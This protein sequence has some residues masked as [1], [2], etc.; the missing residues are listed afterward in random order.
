MLF[1]C[2]GGTFLRLLLSFPP[3]PQC[4][5]TFSAFYS[6]FRSVVAT[7]APTGADRLPSH[8]VTVQLAAK[9]SSRVL[10]VYYGVRVRPSPLMLQH[11]HAALTCLPY[12]CTYILFC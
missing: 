9:W 10:P 12:Q 7:I 1:A 11:M 5:A 6:N 8:P 2:L 4:F 3:P